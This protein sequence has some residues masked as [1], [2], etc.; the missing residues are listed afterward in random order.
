MAAVAIMVRVNNAHTLL[1]ILNKQLMILC[2]NFMA[3]S[4]NR[5]DIRLT[6]GT[7]PSRGRLEVR[8]DGVWGTVCNGDF[9]F[10]QTEADIAC[11]QLQGFGQASSYGSYI[12]HV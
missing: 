2:V 3:V 8:V 10:G 7:S 6:G 9:S 4:G 1:F 12:T 11:R 5:D